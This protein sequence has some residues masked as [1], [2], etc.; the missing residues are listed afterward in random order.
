CDQLWRH[1]PNAFGEDHLAALRGDNDPYRLGTSHS[2]GWR[3]GP[4]RCAPTSQDFRLVPGDELPH[5][6][7]QCVAV[8]A[9]LGLARPSTSVAQ[10]PQSSRGRVGP[11]ARVK[12]VGRVGGLP[13][14]LYPP[15][16]TQAGFDPAA[17][18]R[19]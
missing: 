11:V 9:W 10:A 1:G 3:L 14:C 7:R 8:Q 12:P 13:R 16:V 6:L 18:R 15:F 17:G 5:S 4:G 19:L 2:R